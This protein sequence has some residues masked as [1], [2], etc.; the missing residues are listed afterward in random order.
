MRADLLLE[1]VTIESRSGDLDSRNGALLAL[2]SVDAELGDP[3]VHRSTL[4]HRMEFATTAG[5]RVMLERAA[6]ALR[7]CVSD[8]DASGSAALHLAEAEMA[9]TLGRL[10]E[11]YDSA[12]AALAYSRAAEDEA[13]QRAR[14]ACLAQ[15][16]AHRGICRQPRGYSTKPH[17]LPNGPPIRSSNSL[18]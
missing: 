1:S 9:F 10:A 15:A 17:R 4:L 12:N 5:D 8:D 18:R 7:A 13:G 14:F 6:A 3:E 11:A 16:E 2:E